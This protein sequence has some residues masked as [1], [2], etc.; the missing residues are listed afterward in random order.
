M[1]I[2]VKPSE[3]KV[4]SDK[5]FEG[6]HLNREATVKTFANLVTSVE[7]PCVFGV[8]ADWGYGKS[9]FL[10][11]F[12]QY[13]VN[14][15]IPVV[16]FNAW[17]A[18]Y[19]ADPLTAISVELSQQLHAYGGNSYNNIDNR[20]AEFKKHAG[21]VLRTR[22]PAILAAAI[23]EIPFIGKP[24]DATIKAFTEL[25]ADGQIEAYEKARAAVIKFR[26]SLAEVAR[27]VL[28]P[29]GQGVLVVTIDE[30]DR[31]RPTYAV[32]LLEVAKH[33]FNVERIV[34]VLAIN[35][36]ELAHSVQALYGDRFDALGY[37]RRFIDVDFKLPNPDRS[38][39]ISKAI[40][41]AGFQQPLILAVVSEN[42]NES[43]MLR[44]FLRIFLCDPALSLRTA[45]Q[46]IYNLSLVYASLSEN[47]VPLLTTTSILMIL[48]SLDRELYF[49]FIENRVSDSDVCEKVFN[50]LRKEF[51]ETNQRAVCAFE[52][53][54]IA[55]HLERDCDENW[56]TGDMPHTPLQ[57]HYRLLRNE[58]QESSS[59][60]AEHNRA[61][62][63][64]KLLEII[65][66]D[67]KYY[68]GVMFRSAVDRIELISDDFSVL[69]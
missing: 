48:K 39:F 17:E 57:N 25:H 13:L 42:S 10:R 11:M 6:D 30:L 65:R 19:F 33:L 12:D 5:P 64:L 62:E 21:E 66:S 32:E 8:D 53:W 22:T 67:S 38:L 23:A 41:S 40:E 68:R 4:T 56:L 58:S 29:S 26:C 44:E 18:D 46:C 27:S 31:C 35:R 59:T 52:A 2:K 24:M 55:C 20:I 43:D 61:I 63:V 15:G 60:N 51:V 69:S 54:V 3:V 1:K 34:L 49:S 50:Q 16:S 7:S 36:K 45:L 9:T 28:A 37:L 14:E 47:C